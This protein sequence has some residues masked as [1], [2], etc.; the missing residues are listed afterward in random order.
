[1]IAGM[2]AKLPN[3]VATMALTL[4]LLEDPDAPGATSS[5]EPWR[6]PPTSLS[7]TARMRSVC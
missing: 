3:Q 4:H 1:M 5:G 7:T 2:H 6:P